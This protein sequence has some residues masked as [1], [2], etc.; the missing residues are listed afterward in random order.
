MDIW[1]WVFDTERNLREA[2]NNRLA[3][4]IESIPTDTQENRPELVEAA[5]PEA[6][7]GARAIKNQW[8]EVYFRHWGI[9]NRMSDMI[10]GEKALPEI[11]SLLEFSHRDETI[12]CPQS[13]C[14]TQDIAMC[15]GN[16]DGPGWV[17]ERLAVAQE[18]LARINP[19]WP[20]FSCISEEYIQALLDA[21]RSAE[22]LQFL[23]K[24]ERALFEVGEES[25]DRFV[26]LYIRA[27]CSENRYAEALKRLDAFEAKEDNDLSIGQ[28]QSMDI[29]RAILLAQMQQYKAA[30]ELLPNWNEL[31]PTAYPEWAQTVLTIAT[32]DPQYNHWQIGRSLQ[33]S[34]DYLS[35]V[36]AHHHTVNVA[37]AHIKLALARNAHWTAQRAMLIAQK[38]LAKLRKPQVPA[39]LLADLTQQIAIATPDAINLPVPATELAAYIRNLDNSSPEDDVQYLL[40]ACALLPRDGDL[41]SLTASALAACG[42]TDEAKNHLLTFV[43]ANPTEDG[44]NY[45]LV[46][47]MLDVQDY[48][49]IKQLVHEIETANPSAALWFKAQASYAQ[50]NYQEACL[51]ASA[52]VAINPEAK[53]ARDL[54]ASAALAQQDLTTALQLRQK[55]VELSPP[56]S[57]ELINQ[58]WTLLT[59]ASA[60][61]DWA[62]VRDTA[63]E[64][65]FKLDE[66]VDESGIIEEDWGP[67]YIEFKD[68]LGTQIYYAYRTGPATARILTH[69]NAPDT[70]R[71]NDW[72]AFN[73]ALVEPMPED[74][75]ARK[76]FI[77]TF[78]VEHIIAPGGFAQS[79]FCDGAYPGDEAFETF[80]E[81]LNTQ[82]WQLHVT[83]DEDY[84]VTNPHDINGER[85]AGCHFQVAAPNTLSDRAI[86][87]NLL[88][89]TASWQHPICWPR[90]A[91]RLGLDITRHMH[92]V[93][94][95]GL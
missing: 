47:R 43:R 33:K 11:V 5:M 93:E 6:L 20:C 55:L 91:D 7:A 94:Q 76:N 85:L 44:P 73:T 56:D 69:K 12:S 54:W 38:H 92:I 60:A 31:K 67:V 65:G 23:E 36:G 39:K 75:E 10:E 3:D 79:V 18:A 2:G 35:S 95:Y 70:Q 90:F 61:Q 32:A 66:P 58:L 28:Q 78:R 9:N 88:A 64:L 59:V 46:G 80:A 13:V 24:Q 71:L 26:K 86:N 74:E 30:W 25:P 48:A 14:A 50:K 82:G 68:K 72:V 37:I 89:L 34:V 45:E 40:Q 4:L 51:H 41:A 62:V 49:G 1:K 53:G 19:E 15:Y 87:D 17:D 63:T 42:A 81:S 21:N 27:L 16:M 52:Y 29:S 22:A 83:S 57:E 84:T 77:C 8:L